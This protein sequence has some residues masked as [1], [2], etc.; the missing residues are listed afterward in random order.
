MKE[1][2]NYMFKSIKKKWYLAVAW[3]L[4][5]IIGFSVIGIMRSN[6]ERKLA[7]TPNISERAAA[8]EENLAKYDDDIKLAD[9]LCTNTSREVEELEKYLNESTLMK[10]DPMHVQIGNAQYLTES[11][12]S[13]K[14]TQTVQEY[15]QNGNLKADLIA[16]YPELDVRD[17]SGLI[18]CHIN[19]GNLTFTVL[20]YDA[21]TVKELCEGI[22]KLILEC[23]V[24]SVGAEEAKTWKCIGIKYAETADAGI[25][26]NQT[27][28]RNDAI[29]KQNNLVDYEKKA[30]DLRA[31]KENYA[32]KSHPAKLY[33]FDFIPMSKSMAV[34][35]Y[36]IWGLVF[37]CVTLILA[38]A[39]AFGLKNAEIDKE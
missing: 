36:G 3:L 10:I 21:E 34:L 4:I 16:K 12:K 33:S 35:T 29:A 20:H 32:L 5:C 13:E 22:D 6:Y 23:I 30:T 1:Y 27:T 9:A 14:I 8:Y 26:T 38:L 15:I 2:I 17:L 37:G 24:K 18:R 31:A 11:G 39:V 7:E 25:L 28:K 19:A